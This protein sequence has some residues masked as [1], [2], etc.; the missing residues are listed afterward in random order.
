MINFS[1]SRCFPHIVNLACKAVLSALTNLDYVQDR[2]SNDPTQPSALEDI[3]VSSLRRQH[4]A[5]VAKTYHLDLELLRDVDTRW[6][7]TYYMILRA[8]ELET[9]IDAMLRTNESPEL[10]RYRLEENDWDALATALNILLVPFEFQQALSAEKTPTLG[11]AIKSFNTM[12]QLWKD[13][14]AKYEDQQGP[15][16]SVIQRG[17]NKLQDYYNRIQ[18]VP[19]YIIAMGMSAFDVV[20][21]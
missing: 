4:F 13:L 21:L 7:S 18:D 5:Q 9:V 20:R 14:Q 3:C 15:E 19:A 10:A 17:I 1:E 6:S 8:L 2:P 16:A 11:F 12:T